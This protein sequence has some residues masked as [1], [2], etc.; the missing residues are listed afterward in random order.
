MRRAATDSA[1]SLRGVG[2]PRSMSLKCSYVQKH[3]LGYNYT[4]ISYLFPFVFAQALSAR[5]APRTTGALS[6]TAL[7]LAKIARDTP[8]YF[9]KA[10]ILWSLRQYTACIVIGILNIVRPHQNTFNNLYATAYSPS[11][12]SLCLLEGMPRN[13][14]QHLRFAYRCIARRQRDIEGQ[15]RRQVSVRDRRAAH[16]T[17]SMASLKEHTYP[18]SDRSSPRSIPVHDGSTAWPVCRQPKRGNPLFARK[19]HARTTKRTAPTTTAAAAAAAQEPMLASGRLQTATQTASFLT[20]SC[21]ETLRG[22]SIALA[23]ALSLDSA[24]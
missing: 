9:Y 4:T 6:R 8:H 18:R 23:D 17:P 22:F 11:H 5:H 20:S 24:A 15:R 10:V 16:M 1:W 21:V 14:R 13:R 2:V 3:P 7:M 19:R 12:S